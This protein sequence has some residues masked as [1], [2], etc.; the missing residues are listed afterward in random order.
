M[1]FSAL[2]RRQLC[3]ALQYSPAFGSH[4]HY[5][6]QTCAKIEAKEHLVEPTIQMYA[7]LR[8]DTTMNTHTPGRLSFRSMHKLHQSSLFPTFDAYSMSVSCMSLFS[9]SHD[10]NLEYTQYFL[11]CKRSILCSCIFFSL[12]CLV[13]LRYEFASFWYGFFLLLFFLHFILMGL[14]LWSFFCIFVMYFFLSHVY[15]YSTFYSNVFLLS[16]RLCIAL[17]LHLIV[18]W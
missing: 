15:L 2:P 13:N 12:L 1:I 17:Y 4:V 3:I 16:I 9:L 5:M 18:V 6:V 14:W 7:G 8:R 11:L 10:S